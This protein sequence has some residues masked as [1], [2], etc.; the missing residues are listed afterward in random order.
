MKAILVTLALSVCMFAGEKPLQGTI[1][2]DVLETGQ[3]VLPG[4]IVRLTARA[5]M[6][7]VNDKPAKH[8]IIVNLACMA[9]EGRKHCA[10]LI[11]GEIT[12]E[13]HAKD[14]NSPADL[15]PPGQ[16]LHYRII[17]SSKAE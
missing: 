17:G 5:R 6:L 7:A 10:P 16:Q 3:E 13:S 1:K 12:M 2:L 4:G 15:T 11:P 8:G 9:N 14:T